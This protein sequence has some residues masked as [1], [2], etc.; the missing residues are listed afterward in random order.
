[1]ACELP[2]HD[3]R[4]IY[5]AYGS[6]LSEKRIR[7]N[8]PSACFVTRAR[9]NNFRLSFTLPS[10]RWKGHAA[11]ILTA[12]G[13]YLYGVVWSLSNTDSPNLDRQEGVSKSIYKRIEV[14]VLV[15]SPIDGLSRP[16]GDGS[17]HLVKCRS[18][19]VVS[20]VLPG[21]NPSKTYHEL[22]LNGAIAA[23]LPDEW[24]E[25]LRSIEHNGEES[26]H[27]RIRTDDQVDYRIK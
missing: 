6:N 3:D 1:M 4:F 10:R 14:E 19:Q 13:E 20:P 27:L 17:G 7:I 24:L 9:L 15:G 11:D 26:D 22:I 23:D 2:S 8:N 21:S 16:A 5:F 12:S 25:Y 18:Y